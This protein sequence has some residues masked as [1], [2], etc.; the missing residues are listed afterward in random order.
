[1][2]PLQLHRAD[3]SV[4]RRNQ[5]GSPLSPP[6]G[7]G[8]DS[9]VARFLLAP[10]ASVPLYSSL[11]SCGTISNSGKPLRSSRK[12]KT[13]CPEPSQYLCAFLWIVHTFYCILFKNSM[14]LTKFVCNEPQTCSHPSR[15]VHETYSFSPLKH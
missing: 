7:R 15:V 12:Y 3:L 11:L 10:P 1:M 5:S 4:N 6:G 8:L 13:F 9:S 2:S 14:L